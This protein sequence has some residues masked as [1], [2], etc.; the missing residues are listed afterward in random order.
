MQDYELK[1]LRNV[2]VYTTLRKI[3]K[4]SRSIITA[5]LSGK[6]KK[7]H[8]HTEIRERS[9]CM[10]R[11]NYEMDWGYYGGEYLQRGLL[12]CYNMLHHVSLKGNRR[13][14]VAYCL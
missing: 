1:F 9:I 8:T 14:G 7:T 12:G 4:M 5:S 6:K 2:K 11:I 3:I 13:F 10:E